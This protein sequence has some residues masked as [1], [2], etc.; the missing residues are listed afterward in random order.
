MA[1][2]DK[3]RHRSGGG[4]GREYR[5]LTPGSLEV[6]EGGKDAPDT[7]ILTGSPIVYDQPY[8]VY[9]A[10]GSFRETMHP[11]V[12]TDL[13]ARDGGVDCVLL[14]NH[15]MR[16]IPLARTTSGTLTLSDSDTALNFRANLDAR[17]Q[18]A[19]DLAIA[20]ERGDITQMSVG[21]QV[22]ND[23]WDASE[24]NRD[25]YSLRDLIDVSAVTHPASPTTS[26]E[27]AQRMLLDMPPSDEVRL[28]RLFAIGVE[29]RNGRVVDRSG[30]V[31]NAANAAHLSAALTNFKAASDHMTAIAQAGGIDPN[32]NAGE[33][34]ASD[35]S[36]SNPTPDTNV[37]T[38]DDD[39]A[40]GGAV[41]G[42]PNGNGPA[43]G[44]QDGAGSRTK[45]TGPN[46]VGVTVR[47][48]E[49]IEP[50]TEGDE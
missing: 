35:G 50:T 21:M 44:S 40:I 15:E 25:V 41:S 42:V 30:K 7:I 31:L 49:V 32:G 1:R 39:G 4:L 33:S 12:A 2:S 37:E 3:M 8:T 16:S 38:P 34:S 6:R 45:Y 22:G 11:G 10:F 24:D 27:I 14:V 48:G 19:N 13:L 5:V 23:K 9:D 26:I 20:I 28:R 43:I 46:L 17:S 29:I 36:G 18:Q 47:D